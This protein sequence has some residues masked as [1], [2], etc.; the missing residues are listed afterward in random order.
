MKDNSNNLK[1]LDQ[2]T[3]SINFMCFL[4]A[5]NR[6]ALF[7]SSAALIAGDLQQSPRF[8]CRGAHRGASSFEQLAID[9]TAHF[10]AKVATFT[11]RTAIVGHIV[12][13]VS[14]CI[15][16]TRM[17]HPLSHRVELVYGI[18]SKAR[19]QGQARR[20]GDIAY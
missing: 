3:F 8:H 20:R 11:V 2:R 5:S 13:V 6:D 4:D 18:V 14:V 10:C 9:D 15:S 19:D 12:V 1:S 7:I 17:L 16:L